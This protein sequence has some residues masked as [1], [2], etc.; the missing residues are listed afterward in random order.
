MKLRLCDSPRVA[1]NSIANQQHPRCCW[2]LYRKWPAGVD[3][4]KPRGKKPNSLFF[5]EDARDSIYTLQ[6]NP[7][8]P[9]DCHFG[10]SRFPMYTS[11][12][13]NDWCILEGFPYKTTLVLLGKNFWASVRFSP[14]CANSSNFETGSSVSHE[15]FLGF[16]LIPIDTLQ[17]RQGPTS[18]PLIWRY[19][20]FFNQWICQDSFQYLAS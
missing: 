12:N 7:L 16:L 4:K 5:F 20:A 9:G 19:H 15:Y 1:S 3:T 8:F 11:K 13:L 17:Q 18:I 2:W 14:M 6:L 10:R